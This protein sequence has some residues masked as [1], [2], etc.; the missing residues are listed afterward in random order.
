MLDLYKLQIFA[1]VVEVGSFSAAAERL[2]MTQPAIS[3]H[4]KALEVSLGRDLFQRG[5]RGVKLTAYGETLYQYTEQIFALVTEAENALVNVE[6]LSS[7]RISIGTTPGIGVYL[8]P[9]WVQGFRE[10]YPQ[11]TVS[12]Q[13]GITSEIVADV[14][15]RRLDIGFIEGELEHP[16]PARL[17]VLVLEQVEQ[18]VIVG[19]KHPFWSQEALSLSDLHNQSFIVRQANSQSRLWLEGEFQRYGLERHIGAEFDNLESMKRAVML[20]TCLAVMPSYVV[21]AELA[22]GLLR[23]IPIEGRPFT[24]ELKLIWDCQM[25]FSPVTRVFL[26]NLSQSYAALSPL[27]S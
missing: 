13:T 18:Q 3:Q 16:L 17:S 15:A 26:T 25:Q 22:Q 5:W 11:L 1:V 10:R 19:Q 21:Q 27:S 14:L 6:Q 9:E 20:G 4:M 24:R 23:L 2:Y 8:A 7:G 12:L